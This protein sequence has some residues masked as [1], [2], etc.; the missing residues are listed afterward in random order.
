MSKYNPDHEAAMNK[1][2]ENQTDARPGQMFGYPGYKVNGKLA[3]GLFENGIIVKVGADKAAKLIADG[4][5]SVFEPM[6]GR[7][8]RDWVLL[9]DHFDASASL[10]KDAVALV[11]KETGG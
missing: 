10:F 6:P 11:K 8:W 9:T 2:M 1:L 5:A 7:A 4:K 3:V